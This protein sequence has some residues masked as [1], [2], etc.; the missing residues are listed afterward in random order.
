[1]RKPVLVAEFMDCSKPRP[2]P[3]VPAVLVRPVAVA[4]ARVTS[5]LQDDND[6]LVVAQRI[7]VSAMAAQG[8]LNV[9]QGHEPSADRNVAARGSR[10]LARD[11]PFLMM[12][13]GE[14]RHEG[15]IVRRVIHHQNRRLACR[16]AQIHQTSLV[17]SLSK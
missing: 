5:A 3:F 4:F 12:V 9:A 13:V 16:I 11:I 14:F 17:L 15:Q 2:G 1:M 7:L 10:G 6:G 8:I